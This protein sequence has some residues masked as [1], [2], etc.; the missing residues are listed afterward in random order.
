[1]PQHCFSKNHGFLPYRN[2][3]AWEALQLPIRWEFLLECHIRSPGRQVHRPCF[4]LKPGGCPPGA[5]SYWPFSN[6][7]AWEAVPLLLLCLMLRL[8]SCMSGLR[9]VVY[10]HARQSVKLKP[11]HE[12]YVSPAPHALHLR[13][14]CTILLRYEALGM[15][16]SASA[17]SSETGALTNLPPGS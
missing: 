12:F 11:E 6:C 16:R 9:F 8:L 1:M 3:M 5:E 17:R 14:Q 13:F 2:C 10:R 7:M 15:L 4:F